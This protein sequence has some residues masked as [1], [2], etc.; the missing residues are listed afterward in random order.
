MWARKFAGFDVLTDAG[1]CVVR[2]PTLRGTALVAGPAG[3]RPRAGGCLATIYTLSAA[4]TTPVGSSDVQSAT[5]ST[6]AGFPASKNRASAGSPAMSPTR[7]ITPNS[8]ITPEPLPNPVM[9]VTKMAR[10]G[11]P[12]RSSVT[13]ASALFNSPV[14]YSGGVELVMVKA[15]KQVETGHG[16]GVFDGRSFVKFDVALHN[17]SHKPTSLN[18]VV[19]TTS[20]GKQ[21]QMAPP[22]YTASSDSNDLT[23]TAA[24]GA[25][26]YASYGFAVPVVE[27]GN[28]TMIVDFDGFHTSATYTGKVAAS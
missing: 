3:L 18:T 4:A 12:S 16:P 24:P 27:L 20:Y 2:S 17:G 10:L 26:V 21:Q 14:T 28:V 11:Q 22:V 13:A 9:T 5:A 6:S 19:I 7:P 1:N 23:G 8:T 25:T 15:A